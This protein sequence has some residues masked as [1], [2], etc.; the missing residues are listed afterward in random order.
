[1]DD[2][3][4]K[5]NEEKSEI[6]ENWMINNGYNVRNNGLPTHVHKVTG[7]HGAIDLTITS[8]NTKKMVKAWLV[9]FASRKKNKVISDHFYIVTWIDF[10]AIKLIN[11][12]KIVFH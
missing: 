11:D 10:R 2:V 6:V 8:D 4:S 9:D 3:N 1:M 5:E 7:K 12:V